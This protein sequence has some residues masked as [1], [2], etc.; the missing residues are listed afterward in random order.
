MKSDFSLWGGDDPFRPNLFAASGRLN[1]VVVGASVDGR[2]FDRESLEAT[3]RRH[4]L[5]TPFGERLQS[6]EGKHDDRA[7]LAHRLDV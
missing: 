2:S 1:A 4:Q 6:P 7:D 5:E 3:Y